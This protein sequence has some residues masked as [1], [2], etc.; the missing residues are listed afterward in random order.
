MDLAKSWAKENDFIQFTPVLSEPSVEDAWFGRCGFV[1]QSVMQ[2]YPDLSQHEVYAC[3][4]PI[5]VESARRDFL[6]QCSLLEDLFYAD[7]FTSALDAI[8]QG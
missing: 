2:D 5:M 1:H 8:V 7:S 4:A 3:G 6:A